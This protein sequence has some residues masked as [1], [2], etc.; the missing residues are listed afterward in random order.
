[1]AKFRTRA[2]TIDMLGR[3]QIAGIPTAINELFKNAYDA[4]ANHVEIDFYRSDRLFVLRDDGVGMTRED[5]EGRWLTVGTE[6]KINT[7]EPP[8]IPKG[9]KLRKLMGEKGIGRL[10]IAV[11]GSQV[12]VLTRAKREGSLHNLV[13]TYIHWDIFS[14]PGI[15]LDELEIPIREFKD[16][17]LPSAKDIQSMLNEFQNSL[18]NNSRIPQNMLAKIK[19]DIS[20]FTIDSV[21][22]DGFLDHSTPTLT[23]K[24]KGNGT[25]FI[26]KPASELLSDDIDQSSSDLASPLEKALLG[27]TN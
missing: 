12:L 20:L 19:K 2:R 11:I 22:I 9:C 10:S 8:Y 3:Q 25:H 18:E 17:K 4:Y 13:A 16:G 7:M 15:N 21:K 24:D 23:L 14:C 1:M 26:I 6:S 5:F 27:F